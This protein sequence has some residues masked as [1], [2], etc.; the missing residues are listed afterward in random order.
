[1]KWMRFAQNTDALLSGPVRFEQGAL[2]GMLRDPDGSPALPRSS[3]VTG[4]ARYPI[5]SILA[6]KGE[7]EGVFVLRTARLIIE[8][9][10]GDATFMGGVTQLWLVAA[11]AVSGDI[12]TDFASSTPE[13]LTSSWVKTQW[14][15]VKVPPL[16]E[17]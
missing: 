16:T 1:M 11:T 6:K 12:R 7:M 9:S 3:V 8:V 10:S 13:L 4:V 2:R 15:T 14:P 5:V 17:P